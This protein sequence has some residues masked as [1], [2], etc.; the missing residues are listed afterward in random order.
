MGGWTI[1]SY[2]THFQLPIK[3]KLNLLTILL[4]IY[5]WGKNKK[6]KQTKFNMF[7]VCSEAPVST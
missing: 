3:K 6:K 4:K 1:N 5:G 2:G 7:F